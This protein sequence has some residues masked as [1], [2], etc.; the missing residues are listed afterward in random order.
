M[1]R[2]QKKFSKI[3]DIYVESIY[4]FIFIKVNSHQT[5]EDLTSEAFLKTWQ[6]FQ[7]KKKKEIKN[8]RAFLYVTARHLVIDFY[9]TKK[10]KQTLWI[11]DI[12]EIEDTGQQ[13]EEIENVRSD[14]VLIQ[15][16]LKALKQDYQNIIIWRYVDGLSIREI[17]QILDKSSGAVRVLL[18]RAM[19]QLKEEVK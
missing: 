17:A 2:K 7:D 5:A 6:T 19:N 14:L 8:P 11:E 1:N 12:K 3:Y 18:H 10:Q 4:R 16:A 15:S 13:L 9:R